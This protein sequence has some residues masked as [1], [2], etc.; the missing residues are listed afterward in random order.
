MKEAYPE[1]CAGVLK[2]F[3]LWAVRIY[4]NLCSVGKQKYQFEG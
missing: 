3:N 1:F 2:D 4:M